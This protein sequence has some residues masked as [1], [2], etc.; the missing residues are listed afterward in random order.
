MAQFDHG[1]LT[2]FAV[3][4]LAFT[5]KQFLADF[6]L[7]TTWMARG[8]ERPTQFLA[9]L[10]AHA[11]VHGVSTAVIAV[12]A[13]PGLWLLGVVDFVVHFAID[14]GKIA[15]GRRQKW[16]PPD[17]AFWVFFGFDQMLH[18]LTGLAF[19]FVLASA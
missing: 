5:V 7:Q 9:P 3:L 12:L 14:F 8:K 13:V 4:M 15:I 19:A 6:P 17:A 16:Q 2:V 18:H 1:K 11:L 10:A